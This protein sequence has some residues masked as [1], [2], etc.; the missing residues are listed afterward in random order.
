MMAENNNFAEI[1]ELQ[2]T[3]AQEDSQLQW[4]CLAWVHRWPRIFHFYLAK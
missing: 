2:A 4:P 1:A 3:V